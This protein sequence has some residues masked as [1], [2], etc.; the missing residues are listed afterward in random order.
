[1]LS[2][3]GDAEHLQSWGIP[4]VVDLP[5][6][7]QNL[8]DHV[9][10]PIIYQATQDVHHVSTSSGIAE[11]ELF[12]HS[13]NNSDVVPDLHGID[14]LRVVDA[15]IMP[16]ITIGNTNAPTIMIGEKA[17]DLIKASCTRQ[18]LLTQYNCG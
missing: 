13:E 2:G 9:H 8:R 11:A 7:G 1:M 4:V 15:S 17:A 12:L 6:V 5:G 3:I 16:T 10:V 14:G 18:T